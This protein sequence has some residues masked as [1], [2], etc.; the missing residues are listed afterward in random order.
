MSATAAPAAVAPAAVAETHSAV[1]FFVGDRAYKLKKPVDLGFLD[2][3]DRAA[4]GPPCHR[5]V[6]LNR[7]LAPDVYLGVADV[8]GPD[9]ERVRPPGRHAPHAGRAPAVDPRERGRRRRRRPVAPR[10]PGRRLP[11]PGRAHRRRRPTPPAATPGGAVGGQHRRACWPH[12]HGVVDLDEVR[13]RCD[14]LA[15]RYLDGRGPLFA[16]ADRPRAGRSTATATCSPTTSSASTTG[17]GC[18]TA[19]SSTTALRLG[20]VPRR[21]RLPGHGPR[22]PR[23]PRPRPSGSCDAYR[24]HAGDTWPASLAHHH[25]AYR[26]Q[27]RAKV[28][29][30]P[31]RPG[32]QRRR[33]RRLATC[34]RSLAATSRPG[35]VRLVLVGGLPGTGKSTLAAG[36]GR[37]ARGDRAAHRRGAQGAGRAAP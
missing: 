15:K 31:G 29:G 13:R 27:V 8:I 11:R 25:V 3:R 18:S 7:R 37:R 24:E 28:G 35:V 23:P 1:V 32:R 5:E 30:H 34:S 20:D 12:G 22:A 36:L 21:R 16:R 9:G 2:F 26:A 6:E 17:R 14:A 10:P 4:R 19:S 33:G